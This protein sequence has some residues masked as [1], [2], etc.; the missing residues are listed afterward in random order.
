M[1]LFYAHQYITTNLSKVGGLNDSE[2][3]DIVLSSTDGIDTSKPG[4]AL[5]SYQNP[6][7]ILKAEWITYT[8][9]SIDKELQGVQRG[10]EGSSPKNHDN[11]CA[12]AFPISKSHINN[13]NDAFKTEH[14]EDGTHRLD[15]WIA[16]VDTWV[17]VSATSFKI[18]GKDVRARFPKGTKIKLTQ[19]SDKYF[20]VAN[21]AFSTDTT[22]TVTGGSDYSLANAAIDSPR[23]SYAT[24]PQGFPGWFSWTP[25]VT[26]A[27]GTANPTSV[28]IVSAKF[29]ITGNKAD[30]HLVETFV[31]GSGDRYYITNTMPI[32]ATTA[33]SVPV[34]GCETLI[35]ASPTLRYTYWASGKLI[36]ELGP[37]WARDGGV[38]IS[39]SFSF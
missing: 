36:M 30:F 20:Y 5:L 32:T 37:G 10:Q 31:R 16:D 17:Y 4:I 27:G 18:E 7:D 29:S 33:D 24:T 12:I 2:T 14:N 13:L 26:Y 3:E 11:G 35:N 1:T 23:Y 28:N 34:S 19:T 38:Y 6:L 15:G 8:S 39:G 25:T 21:T 9:I 22:V